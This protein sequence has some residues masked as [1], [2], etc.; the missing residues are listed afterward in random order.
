MKLSAIQAVEIPE[1]K[2]MLLCSKLKPS[3]EDIKTITALVGKS[4]DWNRFI[5]LIKEHKLFPPVYETLKNHFKDN[6]PADVY[7]RVEAL[8]KKN[9]HKCLTNMAAAVKVSGLL[10]END[11]DH[12][13][14]K[15]FCLSQMLYGHPCSRYA[16]DIDL[17]VDE[18]MFDKSV[19]LFEEKGYQQIQSDTELTP[20]N[21]GLFLSLTHHLAFKCPDTYAKIELHFR[22]HTISNYYPMD[23]A[24][25]WKQKRHVTINGYGFPVLGERHALKNLTL[26]GSSHFW[27]R[28]FWLKDIS[29]YFRMNRA[30]D[31][32]MFYNVMC[33][34]DLSRPTSEMLYFSNTIYGNDLPG[35]VLRDIESDWFLSVAPFMMNYTLIHPKHPLTII[36]NYFHKI[37]DHRNI[38]YN[39]KKIKHIFSMKYYKKK[40]NPEDKSMLLKAIAKR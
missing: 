8:R 10:Y 15:G 31:E 35:N 9:L 26:H 4:F 19:A 29:D 33:A 34:D 20:E 36:F 7:K 5:I 11:I 1:M 27:S 21:K 38:R 18:H 30:T 32:Q 23:F 40:Y 39:L 22:F 12:L 28:L 24:E 37:F 6:V 17:I 13:F 16:G 2:A 14:L 3:A 25:A